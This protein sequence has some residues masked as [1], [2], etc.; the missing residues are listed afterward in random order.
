[1]GMLLASQPV[2]DVGTLRCPVT[3]T[4]KEGLKNKSTRA[5]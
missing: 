4:Q 2:L 5:L 1:M 3:V